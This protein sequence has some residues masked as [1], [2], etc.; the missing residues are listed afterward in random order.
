MRAYLDKETGLWKLGKDGVPKWKTKEACQEEWIC[1]LAE[2]LRKLK[3]NIER[4]K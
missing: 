3:E 1:I 2:R 4:G